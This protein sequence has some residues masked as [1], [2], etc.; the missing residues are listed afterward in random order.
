MRHHLYHIKL[1][2][3]SRAVRFR[4]AAFNSLGVTLLET[5]V[6]L[7]IFTSAGTAVLLGV[8]AAHSS[9]DTTN[10]STVAE[11]LARIQ[12]EYVASLPYVAAPGDYA[13]IVDDLSL[14]LT[15]PSGFSVSAS[16]K[17]YLPDDGLSGSIEKVVATVTREG[18]TILVLETLR[19]TP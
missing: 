13:S 17:T 11:N 15:I 7:G 4:S 18:Q 12:M 10:A 19:S 16:A 14:N 2:V 3:K 5:I 1:A 9:S 6:A 8:G